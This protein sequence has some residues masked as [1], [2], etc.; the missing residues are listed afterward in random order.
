[1][2]HKST[3]MLVLPFLGLHQSS[4]SPDNGEEWQERT[5]FVILFQL[6]SEFAFFDFN[7]SF[8]CAKDFILDKRNYFEHRFFV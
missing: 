7:D 3:F 6:I 4:I 1:M 8:F 2:A 5:V